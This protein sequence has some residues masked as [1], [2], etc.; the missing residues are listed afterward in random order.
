M[1][2]EGIP[3][4]YDTM[5]TAESLEKVEAWRCGETLAFLIEAD[6]QKILN[7]GTANMLE[8]KIHGIECDYLFCGISRWKDGFPEMLMR[9]IRFRHL[10]PTHHDEFTL[11]LDQ[12]YLR[13]DLRRLTEVIPDLKSFEVPVLEWTVLPQ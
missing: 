4:G 9:N 1:G 6:G 11:P 5:P 10:I 7:L 12:F 8:E 3:E 2:I 13:N